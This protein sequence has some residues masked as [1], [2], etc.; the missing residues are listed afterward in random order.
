MAVQWR[1]ARLW[2]VLPAAALLLTWV[3][4]LGA[5]GILA[6][7]GPAPDGCGLV[8]LD[9]ELVIDRSGSMGQEEWATGDPPQVR[10]FYAKAAA[11]QLVASL[12]ANGGVGAGQRHHVGLTSFGDYGVAV[13]N[14]SLG[15][16]SAATVG[17]AIDGLSPGAGT[18]L[19]EGMAAGA[20]D[21]VANGRTTDFGLDV[22]RVIV[23]LSDGRPNPDDTGP[24]GS[25]PTAAQISAFQASSD[26][27]YSIAV[28]EGGTNLSAV[29]LPLMQS[30]AKDASRYRHV[31]EGSDLPALFEDIF[32]ELTCPTAPPTE[33]PPAAG[34]PTPTGEVLAETGE[35]TLPPTATS[36]GPL[37]GVGAWGLPV[38]LLVVAS[39]AAAATVARPPDPRAGGS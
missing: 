9:V 18:P 10:L 39:L 8:P 24:T 35:P 3:L 34:S 27:V 15:G 2:F 17:A 14:V 20:A 23:I 11:N 19:R 1:Q 29:D 4:A 37:A 7:Q 28:G 31:V 22:E 33:P 6:V 16:S 13:T 21:M 26:V 32:Q 30:L 36:V 12:D 5:P 25:R 38:L